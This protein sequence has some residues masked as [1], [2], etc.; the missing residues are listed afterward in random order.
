VP[1]LDSSV[2]RFLIFGWMSSDL[3]TRSTVVG[4]SLCLPGR[5]IV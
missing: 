3:M 5:S 2:A 4:A 1:E